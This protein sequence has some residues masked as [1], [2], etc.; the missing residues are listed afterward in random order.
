MY[1]SIQFLSLIELQR[2]YVFKSLCFCC[3]SMCFHYKSMGRALPFNCVVAYDKVDWIKKCNIFLV[4][5]WF[6]SWTDSLAKRS[7]TIAIYLSV[8]LSSIYLSIYDTI[9]LFI[10]LTIQLY[11]Y[12][13]PFIHQPTNEPTCLTINSC[14]SQS[15]YLYIYLPVYHSTFLSN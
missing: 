6:R 1:K 5:E 7:S 10:W 15:I 2:R 9:Y 13:Y 14:F 11:I 12:T 8:Y 3:S 4:H